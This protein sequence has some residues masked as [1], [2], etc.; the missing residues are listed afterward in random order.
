MNVVCSFVGICYV[1]IRDVSEDVVFIDDSISSQDIKQDSR[2]F[3]CFAAVVSLEHRDH[4][5]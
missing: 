5:G 1:K 2:V 3:D 4:V